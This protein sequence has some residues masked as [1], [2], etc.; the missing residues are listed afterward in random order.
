MAINTQNSV[1]SEALQIMNS[2]NSGLSSETIRLISILEWADWTIWLRERLTAFFH[3]QNSPTAPTTWYSEST[4]QKKAWVKAKIAYLVSLWLW[5]STPDN[6]LIISTINSTICTLENE[7]LKKQDFSESAVIRLWALNRYNIKLKSTESAKLA[8]ISKK[9]SELVKWD[10]NLQADLNLDYE[11]SAQRIYKLKTLINALIK[12]WKLKHDDADVTTFQTEFEP[13][14]DKLYELDSS[15]HTLN[16]T[17][18][19]FYRIQRNHWNIKVLNSKDYKKLST[20]IQKLSWKD[21]WTYFKEVFNKQVWEKNEIDSTVLERELESLKSGIWIQEALSEVDLK[22]SAFDRNYLFFFSQELLKKA[23][24]DF[25]HK[26]REVFKDKQ[27]DFEWD[28]S[29]WRKMQRQRII[30]FMRQ[31]PPDEASLE[32]MF[33]KDRKLFVLEWRYSRLRRMSETDNLIVEWLRRVI[34]NKYPTIWRWNQRALIETIIC[35]NCATNELYYGDTNRLQWSGKNSTMQNVL[36]RTNTAWRWIQTVEK[37]TTPIL[38][39][40]IKFGKGTLEFVWKNAAGLIN[41]TTKKIGEILTSWNSKLQNKPKTWW[42]KTLKFPFQTALLLSKPLEWWVKATNFTTTKATSLVWWAY[43]WL[44]E[45][46]KNVSDWKIEDMFDILTKSYS[47]SLCLLWKWTE[48]TWDRWYDWLDVRWKRKVLEHFYQSRTS[49]DVRSIMDAIDIQTKIQDSSPYIFGDEEDDL[50]IDEWVWV[51]DQKKAKITFTE[52]FALFWNKIKNLKT[53]LWS[54]KD[55][56]DDTTDKYQKRTIVHITQIIWSLEDQIL[57]KDADW[58]TVDV[59]KKQSDFDI[60]IWWIISRF[61]VMKN[62]LNKK[63]G[64]LDAEKRKLE[65]SIKD[66]SDDINTKKDSINNKKKDLVDKESTYSWKDISYINEIKRIK[67]EISSNDKKIKKFTSDLIKEDENFKIENETLNDQLKTAQS[68]KIKRADV[69]KINTEINFKNNEISKIDTE[70]KNKINILTTRVN[71]FENGINDDNIQE[72]AF[73]INNIK[74]QINIINIE[75][76]EKKEKIN[77]E[78]QILKDELDNIELNKSKEEILSEKNKL[79]DNYKRNKKTIIDNREALESINEDLVNKIEDTELE[80]EKWKNEFETFKNKTNFEIK[81]LEEEIK[82]L[83]EE[84]E[85][86]KTK[87]PWLELEISDIDNAIKFV[88]LMNG[89][90]DSDLKDIIKDLYDAI[91]QDPFDKTVYDTAYNNFKLAISKFTSIL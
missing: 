66:N 61:R 29:V 6:S 19:S 82:K 51:E 70:S 15:Y 5:S 62:D 64:S 25:D 47:T 33:D 35:E 30:D 32:N 56:L 74:N 59:I 84:N 20:V 34:E 37:Y 57:E 13:K 41:G 75:S 22:E 7:F 58:N 77:K 53:G 43:T 44:N 8:S 4:L 54:K 83:T 80:K 88:K 24:L 79:K 14:L 40:L 68:D 52:I 10:K 81:E 89:K 73:E 9:L 27:R 67:N 69:N 31:V 48:L 78:L 1:E 16:E 87:I 49:Q 36:G 90:I 42:G 26:K 86:L 23:K 18:N 11:N 3:N 2:T 55:W 45:T 39:W 85:V 28:V 76:N 71:E 17:R 46:I 21:I 60:L 38:K 63:S 91:K 50:L 65:K 12:K 72:V